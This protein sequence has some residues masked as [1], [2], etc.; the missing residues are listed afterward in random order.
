MGF[1]ILFL[2]FG[3]W[4]LL[5]PFNETVLIL[6]LVLPLDWLSI[7]FLLLIKFP[8]IFC[9][10]ANCYFGL[11]PVTTIQFLF[12]NFCLINLLNQ[13]SDLLL[14]LEDYL[15]NFTKSDDLYLPVFVL[16]PFLVFIFFFFFSLFKFW[17]FSFIFSL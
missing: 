9:L 14:I 11:F 1:S 16:H 5:E 8:N 6:R 4:D 17:I 7:L 12:C 2:L 10:K 3:E 15:P 13:S